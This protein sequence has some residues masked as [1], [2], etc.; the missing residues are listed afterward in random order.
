MLDNSQNCD[1]STVEWGPM[2]FVDDDTSGVCRPLNSSE[3]ATEGGR[4][5]LISLNT[6]LNTDFGISN[7]CLDDDMISLQPGQREHSSL[8]LLS[9]VEETASHLEQD[10]SENLN[11]VRFCKY[12][13]E[14]Q[15]NNKDNNEPLTP[16]LLT[17]MFGEDAQTK[18]VKVKGLFLDKT[19]ID[20]LESTWHCKFPDKLSASRETSKQSF[21]VGKSA[22]DFL[23]VPILDELTERLLV[24][25]HGYRAVFGNSRSLFSQPY[26]SIE[27]IAYQGQVAARL[28][29]VC[30]CYTQQALGVLLSNLKRESPNLNK[31]VQNVRDIFAMSTK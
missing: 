21:P 10:N 7:P 12:S 30:L 2:G 6:D 18:S 27:K 15:S 16:D 9:S 4:R 8:G 17:E 20:I 11:R 23:Q 28:S 19:Q 14:T 22:E 5:P 3:N 24:K 1:N 31:A 25:K 29:V 13:V 26:K